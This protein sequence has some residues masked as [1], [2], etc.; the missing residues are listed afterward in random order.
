M[1]D[2]EGSPPVES[3]GRDVK[4]VV[5]VVADELGVHGGI[6][7]DLFRHTS[8]IYLR[9]KLKGDRRRQMYSTFAQRARLGLAKCGGHIRH[10]H[11]TLQVATAL[12]SVGTHCTSRQQPATNKSQCK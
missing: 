11:N 7:H 12:G 4:V 2:T 10:M 6:E 3:V 5:S 9:A 1:T 8:Y